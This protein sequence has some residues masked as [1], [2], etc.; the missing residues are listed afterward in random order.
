[1]YVDGPSHRQIVFAQHLQVPE[2]SAS[3]SLAADPIAMQTIPD[4]VPED[5]KQLLQK[6]PSIL[7][8]GD[9]MP[10]PTHGVEHRIHTGIHTPVFSKS[11]RLD[12]EKLEIAKA[13]F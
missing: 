3:V 6:F 1:L 12:P 2:P 13:E 9:V 11:R 4:S 8:M 5:V 10:T 7:C